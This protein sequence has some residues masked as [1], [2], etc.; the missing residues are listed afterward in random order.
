[1]YRHSKE[2]SDWLVEIRRDFHRHPELS[3]R[4]KR[5]TQRI[6]ALLETFGC[7]VTTFPD[8]TG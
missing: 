7:E 4:E 5:T 8:I 3:L 1:M 6:A 2:F